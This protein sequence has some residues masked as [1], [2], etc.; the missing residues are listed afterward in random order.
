MDKISIHRAEYFYIYRGMFRVRLPDLLTVPMQR[1]W[2]VN[3]P[4]SPNAS[5]RGYSQ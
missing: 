5:D 4:R 3:F 2:S 1:R